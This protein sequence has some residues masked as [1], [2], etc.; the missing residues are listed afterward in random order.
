MAFPYHCDAP[1]SFRNEIDKGIKLSFRQPSIRQ[2]DMLYLCH[3]IIVI[4]DTPDAWPRDTKNNIVPRFEI[5]ETKIFRFSFFLCWHQNSPITLIVRQLLWVP[6]NQP[7]SN[8]ARPTKI[9]RVW[10]HCYNPRRLH[11]SLLKRQRKRTATS[12]RIDHSSATSRGGLYSIAPP[13]L[14]ITIAS[15]SQPSP[16]LFGNDSPLSPL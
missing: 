2:V 13:S 15:T 14:V 16:L 10:T 5:I 4:K 6:I 11:L 7:F 1:D 3:I 12:L 8:A 9:S